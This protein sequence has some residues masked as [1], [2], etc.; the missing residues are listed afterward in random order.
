M[1]WKGRAKMR[2]NFLNA[3]HSQ[4]Q[5]CW[6]C[7]GQCAVRL[8]LRY[9]PHIP[10]KRY[11]FVNPSR[12]IASLALNRGPTAINHRKSKENWAITP[13]FVISVS[14]V[15]VH[16]WASWWSPHGLSPQWT[17]GSWTLCGSAYHLSTRTDETTNTSDT[18]NS[19]ITNL[20]KGTLTKKP[21]D[22]IWALYFFKEQQCVLGL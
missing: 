16:W 14:P 2:Q 3:V 4:I 13:G 1:I 9:S 12:L 18:W 20:K 15:P 19:E 6:T 10:V 7:W 11:D 5:W 21:F 17:S 22:M 8:V